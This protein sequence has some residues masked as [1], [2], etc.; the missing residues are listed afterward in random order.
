MYVPWLTNVAPRVVAAE[1]I[2]GPITTA[3]ELVRE[4]SYDDRR[5][6]MNDERIPPWSGLCE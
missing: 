3:V 2:I 4:M 6:T 5:M 1:G